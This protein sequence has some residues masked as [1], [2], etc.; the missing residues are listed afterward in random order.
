MYK[1]LLAKEKMTARYFQ[2]FS[3]GLETSNAFDLNI[4]CFF[5]RETLYLPIPIIY[6][7]L[8]VHSIET[9]ATQDG[10]GIR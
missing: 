1:A 6:A 2:I 8:N 5:Y 7:M 9:F 3:S 4:W 10:P